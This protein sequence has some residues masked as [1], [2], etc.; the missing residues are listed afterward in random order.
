M[1]F[2]TEHI[3]YDKLHRVQNRTDKKY[4]TQ[5]D[6]ELDFLKNKYEKQT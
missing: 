2:L 3:E 1:F 5:I 6:E 4:G